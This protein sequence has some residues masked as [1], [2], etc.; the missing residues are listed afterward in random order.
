MNPNYKTVIMQTLVNEYKAY[1]Q[2]IKEAPKHM[3]ATKF[4]LITLEICG[5]TSI[6]WNI[7]TY[8]GEFRSWAFITIGLGYA[9]LRFYLTFKRGMIDIKKRNFELR[10]Q[11]NEIKREEWEQAMREQGMLK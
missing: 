5:A 11:E 8:F 1:L 7:F 9:V 6:L 2:S 4:G 10:R 3:F